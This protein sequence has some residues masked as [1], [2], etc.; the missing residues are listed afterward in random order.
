MSSVLHLS[1]LL[2]RLR[3]ASASASRGRLPHQLR[4]HQR[5]RCIRRQLQRLNQYQQSQ[6][7]S[8][9]SE[10][11]SAASAASA[12]E[13][14]S[15]KTNQLPASESKYQQ[16]NQRV[17]TS[18]TVAAS[19]SA[20][21]SSLSI[22]FNITF[23]ICITISTSTAIEILKKIGTKQGEVIKAYVDTKVK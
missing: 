1:Q 8:A 17:S 4:M 23:H 13:S 14:V 20:T 2:H 21:C 10:S 18:A 6:S 3:I 7:A 5:H 15:A 9:C 16:A 12:S 19:V 22:G 11:A